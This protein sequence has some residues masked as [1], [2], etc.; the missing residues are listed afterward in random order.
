MSDCYASLHIKLAYHACLWF[1]SQWVVSCASLHFQ[2]T[3]N[4]CLWFSSWWVVFCASLLFKLTN[5]ACS[6][7]FSW[8]VVFCTLICF[9]PVYNDCSWLV[10]Q[11]VDIMP[12]CLQYC[13]WC[14]FLLF[15]LWVAAVCHSMSSFLTMPFFGSLV[16]ESCLIACLV[17]SLHTMTVLASPASQ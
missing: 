14:L 15:R 17:S 6:W 12:W 16:G 4:T 5:H 3:N 11:S 9:K 13:W 2:L 7:F 8:W 1:S 10:S